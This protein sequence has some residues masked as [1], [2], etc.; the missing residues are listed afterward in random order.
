MNREEAKQEVKKRLEEYLR[1][2]GIDT[3]RKFRCLNPAHA[4][5]HPSMSYDAQRQKLQRKL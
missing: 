4:D 1:A 3:S 2:K 5:E